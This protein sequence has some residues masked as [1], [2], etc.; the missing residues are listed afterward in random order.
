M[1]CFLIGSSGAL[2]ML[3]SVFLGISQYSDYRA[4]SEIDGWLAH[5]Q[6]IQ[7][8]IEQKA[9]K[10]NSLTGVGNNLQ[11]KKFPN[12]NLDVFE[13]S[14]SG[15]ILLR[16]GRDGQMI[17]LIPLFSEKG[18]VWRCIGGSRAAIPKRCR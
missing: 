10:Q 18:V 17:V 13:V 6:E 5:V 1:K 9:V 4:L 14:E 15:T 12:S 11:T 7:T 8:E 3:I 16:G 2:L